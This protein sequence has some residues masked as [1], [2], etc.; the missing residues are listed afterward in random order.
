MAQ[1]IRED[2]RPA[3]YGIP[4]HG[5]SAAYY[6]RE[7]PPFF[8]AY[9]EAI[10]LG[11]TQLVG[12]YSGYVALREWLKRRMKNRM[13]AYLIEVEEQA[14][15]LGSLSLAELV[16]HREALYEIRHRALSDLVSE[17]VLADE[18]FTIFQN[19]LRDEFAAIEARIMEKQAGG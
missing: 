11:L 5:G 18:S 12:A 7:E 6:H 14:A 15:D 13:D 3:G 8:V 16:S 1:Q 4:F 19:H 10:S 2:Y 17:R 9:A